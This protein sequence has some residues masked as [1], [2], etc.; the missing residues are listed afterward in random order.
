[1]AKIP[2]AQ[3][4]LHIERL[5]KKLAEG[6]TTDS[7]IMQ[8]LNLNRR[9]FYR[10]KARVYKIFGHIAEKNTEQSLEFQTHVS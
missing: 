2:A 6:C 3:M 1:M 7:E 10:H 9:T 5:A 8:E 4:R